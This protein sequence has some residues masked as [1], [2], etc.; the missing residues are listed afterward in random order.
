ME[1]FVKNWVVGI[2]VLLTSAVFADDRIAI[3]PFCN[4]SLILLSP[5]I[6]AKIQREDAQ[7]REL[8][9]RQALGEGLIFIEQSIAR[10]AFGKI[11]SLA[12]ALRLVDLVADH[13]TVYGPIN[14]VLGRLS[15]ARNWAL[16]LNTGFH[17]VPTHTDGHREMVQQTIDHFP[18]FDGATALNGSP[19]LVLDVG[20]GDG[21]LGI[22]TVVR[23][24]RTILSGID[25]AGAGINISNWRLNEI[26]DLN[27][28]KYSDP[29]LAN[30]GRFWTGRG[31]ASDPH[32][33]PIEQYDAASMVLTLFAVPTAQRKTALQN[34]Y[35]SLKPG[36]KFILID[37]VLQANDAATG[38]QFLKE[39]VRSAYRNNPDLTAL[40]VAILTAK[41]AHS[42]FKTDFMTP[43]EQQSFVEAVG[44]RHLT[45]SQPVYYGIANMQVF[46]KPQ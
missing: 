19:P 4:N 36:A 21:N 37:P 42:L 14:D 32:M 40:D 1:S 34:I 13:P 33:F 22:A 2:L 31:S 29:G 23:N 17:A 24:P 26:T 10:P 41:N 16:Y 15:P 18:R 28:A 43:A 12:D 39:I 8:F 11:E 44:F 38:R 3:P 35:N 46:E 5:E 6:A 25:I 27:A 20:I 9:V 7:L 30:F 45:T